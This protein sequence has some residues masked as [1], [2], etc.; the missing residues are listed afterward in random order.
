MAPQGL[1]SHPEWQG[2]V[3]PSPELGLS[4]SLSVWTCQPQTGVCQA[5]GDWE[6]TWSLCHLLSVITTLAEAFPPLAG[7]HRL[8]AVSTARLQEDPKDEAPTRLTA[9]YIIGAAASGLPTPL[10]LFPF[11]CPGQEPRDMA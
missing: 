4:F 10:L 6:R 9:V 7:S 11:S 8:T 1:G 3:G 5:W 2:V